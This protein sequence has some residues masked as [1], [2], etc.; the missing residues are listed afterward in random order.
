MKVIGEPKVLREVGGGRRFGNRKRYAPFP[1]EIRLCSVW[2]FVEDSA[3]RCASGSFI[4]LRRSRVCTQ[5]QSA[6]NPRPA[7]QEGL[8]LPGPA[9]PNGRLRPGR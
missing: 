9:D 5:F 1:E 4:A 6:Q 7:T 8:M 3:S 2:S